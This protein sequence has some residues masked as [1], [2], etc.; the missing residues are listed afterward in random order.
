MNIIITSL[1]QL[2]EEATTI[3]AFLNITCSEDIGEC[4]ARGNDLAVHL[5]RSGKMLADAKYHQD[6]AMT[7]NNLLC[8]E[9]YKHMPPSIKNKLIE[10]MCAKENYLVNWIE[11]LNRTATHQL[12][13]MVTLISKAKAE[14]N[15]TPKINQP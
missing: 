13:F 6:L 2:E 15:I 3:D 4:A 14:M 1:D 11:R 9:A 10:S 5:A 8:N 7:E 12:S